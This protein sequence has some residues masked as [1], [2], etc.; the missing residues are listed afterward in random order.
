VTTKRKYVEI[1]AR[2]KTMKRAHARPRRRQEHRQQHVT[3][4]HIR[5]HVFSVLKDT[6][7]GTAWLTAL[8]NEAF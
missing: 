6:P 7:R 2:S 3:R 5:G 8:L 1:L 4:R